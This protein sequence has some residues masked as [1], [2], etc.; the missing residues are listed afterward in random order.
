MAN[1]TPLDR[2]LH[3]LIQFLEAKTDIFSRDEV[4]N[5][6]IYHYFKEI[7]RYWSK[8]NFIILT[9]SGTMKNRPPL[10]AKLLYAAYRTFFE[11]SAIRPL[12]EELNSV[13]M[14]PTERDFLTSFLNK[15]HTFNWELALH[16]KSVD[17]RLS[18]ELAVPTFVIQKLRP[19]MTPDFLHL[20]LQEM[21]SQ[22]EK[23]TQPL[24]IN[25]LGA[26][27]AED[28]F[29]SRI[30]SDLRR[31]GIEFQQDS[32]F[33]EIL[34]IPTEKK[35][36][37]IRSE[38]Y[39]SGY[40]VFQD[41]SSVAIVSIL[42]PQPNEL[43]CDLSAA[44]GMKTSLIAQYTQN[45][46]HLIAI[47]VNLHR[48]NQ[49]KQLL[50]HLHVLNVHTLNA[51]GLNLPFP[52]PFKFDKVLLD[53]PCTGSGNFLA[54]PE[55]K[56]RQNKKFLQQNCYFQQKLLESAIDI[57]KPHGT[58][59]YSVC[60]LYPE[61]GETQLLK[62]KDHLKPLDLP[63]W[64]SPSYKIG[65]SSLEGMGRLFPASHHT[66]GFFLAKLQKIN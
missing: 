34:H 54:N 20:N 45:T 19:V 49:M 38:W 61:E 24:R 65:D 6:Q 46:A 30:K 26:E 64:V 62:F 39:R 47:D 22:K 53:A 31:Q 10:Q 44:P 37:L 25:T 63:K 43:I 23:S 36:I 4:D 21:N 17:E 11:N 3:L 29:I 27:D 8:L 14:T 48:V 7:I 2:I 42:S 56:W 32:E 35:A 33:P 9:T 5:P 40:L 60:S 66:Q 50:R 12:L 18:L 52:L 13:S 57:L 16:Q 55:L 28:D 41:K 51:D 59:V 58:L 15:I 1:K